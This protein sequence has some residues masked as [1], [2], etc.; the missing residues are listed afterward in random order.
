MKNKNGILMP[1]TLKI[2][3]AVI[4]IGLLVYLSVSLYGIFA[5]QTKIEQAR[6]TLD[7][8]FAEIEGLEEGEKSDYLVV[9]PKDWV[10]MD[11]K[12]DKEL[13]ICPHP[14]KVEKEKTDEEC[15]DQG[16]CK[17]IGVDLSILQECDI[18]A[19]YQTPDCIS[20]KEIP[21]EIFLERK[22]TI[23]EIK[24]QEDIIKQE[25]I[26]DV[27]DYK[28]YEETVEQLIFKY[29][30]ASSTEK[31]DIK[32]QINTALK[33]YHEKLDTEKQ[34]GINKRNFR[35][36]FSLTEIDEYKLLFEFTNSPY[37]EEFPEEIFRKPSYHYFEYNNK[38]HS[39]KLK[40]FT[41]I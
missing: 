26:E 9:A 13:C 8:I 24:I 25:L 1:E 5:Q 7:Q 30:E 12:T 34:F 14:S 17:S 29:L 15:K 39:I 2:I 21:L 27:L 16:V 31:E 23:I 38:R 28:I 20:L 40:Y 19:M 11:L 33:S 10:I 37:Y 41:H 6:A 35:W 32:T 18:I 36:L 22:K 4:C 3:I